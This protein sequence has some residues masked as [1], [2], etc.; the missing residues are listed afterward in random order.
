MLLRKIFDPR[1]VVWYM[2]Y[3][4]LFSIPLAILVWVLFEVFALRQIALPFSIAATL[5]GALAIFLGFRNNNSYSRWWEARQLWSGIIN[6]SR[7]FAR[8]VFTFADSHSHQANYNKEK[9]EIFK[10]SLIYKQIAWAHALRLHLR[11]QESWVELKPFLSEKEFL[12]LSNTQNKPNY[13]QIMMGK[14][15]Y[16]AMADGTLGGFDSFQM[17]GQL[18]ALANYQGGCERIKNTPLLRQYHYFT[19]L[20]LYAF[21]LLLPFCLIGDFHKLGIPSMMIPIS[22]LIS[23]V[24]GTIAKIGEVNEDPFENRQTDVPIFAI[25]NTIERDLR[26]TLGETDLPKK[27]ELIDGALF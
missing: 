6:S 24:F 27:P 25:C 15:I 10:K 12:E 20:F 26:E 22:I 1:K 7:V 16:G 5:G 2:R 4:L 23:F 17:E 18:L 3:E 13:L 14:Q 19:V 9:S 8:L 11:K 21:M